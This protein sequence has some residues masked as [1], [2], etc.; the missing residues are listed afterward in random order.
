MASQALLKLG[1]IL[2]INW[3][4]PRAHRILQSDFPYHVTS[5]TVNKDSF[6]VDM[7]LLWKFVSRRLHFC[8]FA[9]QI[10]IHAFV[11]MKN[12]YHL[13]VRTPNSNLSQ[14]MCYFNRELSKELNRVT[15]RINQNFGNRYYAS[16]VKNPRYYL[17]LYRYVYRNPVEAGACLKA[18]N[19]Q[20]SSLRQVLGSTKMEFPIFDFPI[21]DSNSLKNLDW[22]N[23]SYGTEEKSR[24][25]QSLKKAIFV[26]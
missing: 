9:F 21:I 14:F 10:E 2:N 19:Y 3:A 7:D 22:L 11:L 1:R 17:T 6:H 26:L 23:E 5:R 20:F 8:S 4:M 15:G 12:H 13:I 16:L 24:I 25:R 18:E